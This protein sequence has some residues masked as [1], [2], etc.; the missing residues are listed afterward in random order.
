[1]AIQPKPEHLLS[2]AN[3][4]LKRVLE[5]DPYKNF[6]QVKDRD[7][8]IQTI[9]NDPAFAPLGLAN[10]KY[11][12]ARI[13]GNLVTSLHRKIG[14]FY[15][16]VFQYLLQCRFPLT[17]QDLK[18]DV[19]LKIGNRNQTRST[20]GMIPITY[21]VNSDL[22][23]IDNSW[24]QSQGLAFEIRSCYQNG[25]SKRIQAGMDMAIALKEHHLTP[26]ML[27]FCNTSLRF[28]LTRLQ[29]SWYLLEG[30]NAFQ[31]IYDL[32]QF[33]LQSFLTSHQEQLSNL[34]AEILANI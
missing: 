4:H 5:Y 13:G 34:I 12:I 19:T 17:E 14:D 23:L 31:F 20:D 24:K 27:I 8:F 33:D 26:V 11:A 2:L 30:E 15:E 16:D 10:E 32:T 9:A 6:P 25:D 21:L 28:P 1:M 7:S 18:F 22:P 3:H 29:Q